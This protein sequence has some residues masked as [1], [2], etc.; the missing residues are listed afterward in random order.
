MSEPP[1]ERVIG[2]LSYWVK[3]TVIFSLIAHAPGDTHFWALASCL[4]QGFCAQ[5]EGKLKSCPVQEKSDI[6][7]I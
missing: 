3:V 2:L 6:E 5:A 4:R 7:P 1:F